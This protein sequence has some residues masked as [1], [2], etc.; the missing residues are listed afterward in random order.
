MSITTAGRRLGTLVKGRLLGIVVTKHGVSP[1]ILHAA[2]VGTRG[3]TS[4]SGT[5]LQSIFGL[6][7]TYATFTAISTSASA[8]ALSGT[9]YPARQGSALW[10]QVRT[11]Q[12][13]HTIERE[14]IGPGGAYSAPLPGTGTYRVQYSRLNGPAVSSRRPQARLQAQAGYGLG[15]N[16]LQPKF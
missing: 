9:I 14:S 10:V 11:G 16:R 1:R 13:W 4:V 2:V 15:P 5:T 3:R 8:G 12:G 6:P 7:T